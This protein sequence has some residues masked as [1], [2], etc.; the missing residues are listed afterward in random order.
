MMCEYDVITAHI[1]TLRQVPSHV[2]PSSSLNHFFSNNKGYLDDREKEMRELDTSNRGY[3]TNSKVYNMLQKG[4]AEGEESSRRKK[5]IY[6]AL[7]LALLL[8]IALVAV[9]LSVG[10]KST[11]SGEKGATN[12]SPD[13]NSSPPLTPPT[14]TP[15]TGTTNGIPIPPLSPPTPT[16]ATGATVY[17]RKPTFISPLK[18][19]YE[20]TSVDGFAAVAGYG[21]ETTTGGEGGLVVTVTDAISFEKFIKRDEP[22]IVQVDGMIDLTE[23]FENRGKK[24]YDVS[25]DTTIVGLTPNSGI[26]GG[27]IKVEGYRVC[28]GNG[29]HDEKVGV[30]CLETDKAAP[31][32]KPPVNNVIIQNLHIVDC[33]DDCIHVGLYAHHVWI[34]HNSLAR[35]KD[36][37]LDIVKGSDLITVS[38]NQFTDSHKTLLLGHNDNNGE[39]DIGKLRVTYHHNYFFK[40]QSRNPR[41][42]FGE[43]VHVYN[44]Y[45]DSNGFYGLAAQTKSG[46]IVEGNFF[47][48]LDVPMTTEISE[49]AGRLVARFNQ[50]RNSPRNTKWQTGDLAKPNSYYEFS[51]F[52]TQLG[53]LGGSDLEE[54]KYGDGNVTEPIRF[55][56]YRLD[57]PQILPQVVSQNAGAQKEWPA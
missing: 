26:K 7:A 33:P 29:V 23:N 18:Y 12:D 6:A 14:P 45:Y 36:G 1:K 47:D 27:G 35:Q 55:Y 5:C 52:N 42:R 39:Q 48:N 21:V 38:W 40:S 9:A 49:D 41:A 34:D 50:Y 19:D 57:D 4:R 2:S 56:K 30:N 43:P 54:F 25:S 10:F 37:I 17:T 46:M 15:A 51:L 44:N 53:L 8:L 13:D 16:P 11:G 24:I 28:N 3:L 20:Q 22:M 31:A 32:K